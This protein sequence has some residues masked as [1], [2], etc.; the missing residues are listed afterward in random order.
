MDGLM[1]FLHETTMPPI[2]PNARINDI[3]TS[4]PPIRQS[5]RIVQNI[6]TSIPLHT[7][8]GTAYTILARTA[9][10]PIRQNA[11][12]YTILARGHHATHTP[13]WTDQSEHHYLHATPKAKMDGLIPLFRDSHA[14]HTPKWPDESQPRY[15]HAPHTPKW[16]AFT[17]LALNRHATHTPKWTDL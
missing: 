8:K 3:T 15:L 10:P 14:T 9:M 2:R 16:M 5:G 7:P 17:I 11:W 4:V 1:P 13:K 12:P 6:T